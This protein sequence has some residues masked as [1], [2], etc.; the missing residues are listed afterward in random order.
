MV[1]EP[2]TGQGEYPIR[3]SGYSRTFEATVIARLLAADEIEFE[4]FTTA[5]DYLDAWGR[6]TM[7]IPNGPTGR[8]DVFVGEDSAATGDASGV[9]IELSIP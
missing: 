6:F 2:S 3:V 1:F 4:T 5:T 9:T 7:E 8:V